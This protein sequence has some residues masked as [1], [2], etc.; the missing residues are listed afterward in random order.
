MVN[1][2]ESTEV[3][4]LRKRVLTFIVTLLNNKKNTPNGVQEQMLTT[5]VRATACNLMQDL[6]WRINTSDKP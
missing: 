3:K 6:A 2:A 4:Q 5:H 1:E